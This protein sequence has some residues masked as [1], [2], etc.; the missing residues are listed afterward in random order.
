MSRSWACPMLPGM[1]DHELVVQPARGRPGVPPGVRL[2]LGGIDPVGDHLDPPFTRALVHQAQLHRLADRD[3]PVGA[4]QIEPHELAQRSEHERVL[5]PLDALGDLGEDVL[6]DDEQRDIEPPRDDEPD[7]PDDRWVGHAEDEVGP[8]AAQRRA[9]GLA[10]IAAVVGGAVVQLR[11][12]VGRRAHA[13][14]PDAVPLLLVRQLVA[15]EMTGDDGDVVVAGQRLAQLREQLRRRLDAGP[16]V[17]V[18]DE[19]PRAGAHRLLTL[20]HARRRVRA[21]AHPAREPRVLAGPRVRGACG[22]GARARHAARRA[23]A[24]RRGGDDDADRRRRTPRRAHAGRDGRRSARDVPR[25]AAAVPVDGDH[26]DAAARAP[27]PA[28]TRRDARDGLP[29]PGNDG[30]RRVVPAC[31]AFPISSSRSGCS[32]RGCGRWP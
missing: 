24:R 12:L 27:P 32:R 6:A 17:L 16:V 10:E 7:V 5:E 18:E 1:H 15:V 2:D 23:R 20:T 22:R 11:A 31:A 4:T 28:A 9:N 25:D 3:D 29:R 14:D 30:C 8:L 13:D 26:A 19:D 21:D